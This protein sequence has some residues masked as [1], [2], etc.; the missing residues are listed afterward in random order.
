MSRPI[1]VTMR[2]QEGRLMLPLGSTPIVRQWESA[3][4]AAD[5]VTPSVESET[6][7]REAPVNGFSIRN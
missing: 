1:M 7:P 2:T 4:P 6:A 3:I 5:Y